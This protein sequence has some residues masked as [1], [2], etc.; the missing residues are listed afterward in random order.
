MRA[1]EHR[2]ARGEGGGGAG[3]AMGARGAMRSDYLL[4]VCAKNHCP[5]YTCMCCAYEGGGAG[6]AT[7]AREPR[8]GHVLRWR[9]A[10]THHRGIDNVA[11]PQMWALLSHVMDTL[12]SPNDMNEYLLVVATRLHQRGLT[13]KHLYA[14]GM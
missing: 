3:R 7:G 5:L 4:C 1:A 10:A 9:I 6:R 2:G 13:E 11:F 12:W 14:L 8:D